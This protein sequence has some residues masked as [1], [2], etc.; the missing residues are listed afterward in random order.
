MI[1]AGSGEAW[2]TGVAAI[3][4][5]AQDPSAHTPSR[6]AEFLLTVSPTDHQTSSRLPT[7]DHSGLGSTR[8]EKS[9]R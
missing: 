1:A 9:A 2:H 7:Q 8:I 4:A 6:F 3:H 5:N